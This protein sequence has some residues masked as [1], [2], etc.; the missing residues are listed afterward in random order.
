MDVAVGASVARDVSFRVFASDASLPDCTPVR[1]SSVGSGSSDGDCS[2]PVVI[3]QNGAVAFS[4]NGFSLIESAKA[5]ASFLPGRW[6]ELVNKE[7]NRNVLASG[8]IAF[9]PGPIE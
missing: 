4:V 3:P 5:Q 2:V 7:N 6:L 1:R 8:G 9:T